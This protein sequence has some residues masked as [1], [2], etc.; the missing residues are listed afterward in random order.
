MTPWI[1]WIRAGV[2]A[3]RCH[4]A[5]SLVAARLAARDDHNEAAVTASFPRCNR[6]R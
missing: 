2:I 1:G 5:C 6:V 3:I 4:P